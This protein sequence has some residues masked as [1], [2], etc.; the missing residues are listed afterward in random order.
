MKR[1]AI[2]FLVGLCSWAA[3][4]LTATCHAQCSSCATPV[5]AYSPV[6]Y[7]SA[8]T[9]T[10][11]KGWY[12]GKLLDQWRMRRYGYTAPTA[13]TAT[14]APNTASY[15]PYTASYAPYTT[16]YTPYTTTN[17][18]TAYAPLGQRQ[19]LMRPVVVSSPVVSEGCS[20]CSYSAPCD[21]C[22]SCSACSSCSGGVTAATYSQPACSSCASGGSSS[23]AT[24]TYSGGAMA[25]PSLTP[26]EATPQSTLYPPAEES[27][28]PAPG[29]AEETS[30]LYDLEA[31]ALYIPADR[32]AQR[33][34]RANHPINRGASV[35]V[36]T[37]VYRKS[38]DDSSSSVRTS[39][40]TTND[41]ADGWSSL[42]AD[43]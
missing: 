18:V 38:V 3:A 40:A 26:N 10:P 6:T 33:P 20:T 23:Y 12:P 35:D 16:N 5:V 4:S 43:R 22:T 2:V 7:Q 24:P 31:P 37:A 11:Y 13:V 8:V 19:V 9:Y 34:A 42:P 28:A 15:A 14:Y 21:S 17:Y 39:P 30:T 27:E 25:A 32:T 29:P 36:Q 41:A 1:P